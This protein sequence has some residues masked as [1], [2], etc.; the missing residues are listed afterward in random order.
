MTERWLFSSDSHI[1]EQPDLFTTRIDR[2]FADRAPRV[3]DHGGVDFWVVD[4]YEGVPAVNPSRAGD[5]FEDAESRRRR[6][7]FSSDVRP[8]AYLPD[9]W[10]ADNESDGVYGG[11]LFPSMSLIFYG[12]ADSELLSAVCRTYTDWAIE[13]AAA[14]P[15]RLKAIAMLNTDDIGAAVAEMTRAR[16]RGASGVLIPVV[17]GERA[18]DDPAYEPLWAAAQDLDLPLNMHIATNRT[19]G[20]WK[21]LFKPSVSVSRPDDWVRVSIADMILSGVF[22]RH[23]RLRVGSVEHEAGWAAFFVQRMDYHYTESLD[24]AGA[25]PRFSDGALPSDFF[26]RNVFVSFSDDD[27]AI[28]NRDIIGV[29]NLMWGNDYPHGESTFPR[30]REIVAERLKGVPDDEF[31]RLTQSNAARLYGVE[32]PPGGP[33]AV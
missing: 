32:V 3:I 23:P 15:A 8:G 27:V 16:E 19:P 13:F 5:R 1:V 25:Y 22:E 26:H 11:V 33:A 14:Y 28:R 4:G 12:I 17:P 7:R 2:R 20:Q 18:Y 9:E 31:V 29:E 21:E 24:F 30:S 10:I 6:V